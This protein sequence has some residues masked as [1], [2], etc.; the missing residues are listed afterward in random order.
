MVILADA[1]G[2]TDTPAYEMLRQINSPI[3]MVLVSRVDGFV[4][5][6][7]LYQLDKY[8]LVDYVENGW[9]WDRK[10][11]HKWTFNSEKF[12]FLN[13]DEYKRFDDFV[14]TKRPLLTFMRE[15]LQDDESK[16]LISIEY[17]CWHLPYQVQTKEQFDKRQLQL[18][19]YWGH[20]HESRRRF[21]GQA[22]LHAVKEDITIIDNIFYYDQFLR[23]NH[24]KYWATIHIPHF[25]RLSMSEILQK[26]NNAKLSLCLPGAGVKC[27]RHSESPVNSVMVLQY[28]NLA[29]SYKWE[30]GFNCIRAFDGMEIETIE[31]A[32]QRNDLYDIYR[33][34]MN[35]VDKYRVNRYISEYILPNIEK[36]S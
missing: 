18:F 36:V 26:N 13:T 10:F 11:T 31:N 12:D 16:I 7:S 30:N 34:G 35:T 5:N 27:F 33:E 1:N 9:N 23:E 14:H 32:L 8:I 19:H 2:R 15:L 29:W 25:A 21:Q 17:P 4:F 22:Y 3:P 20:S 6:Q 28:D 24:R